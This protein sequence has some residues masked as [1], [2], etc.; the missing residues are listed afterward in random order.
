MVMN[1]ALAVL[2]ALIGLFS[3]KACVDCCCCRCICKSCV[4][5]LWNVLALMMILSFLVGSILALVGRI[6]GDLMSLASFIFSED[7]FNGQ[8]PLFLDKMDS[9]AQGYLRRC[10]IGDGNLAEQLNIGNQIDSLN[11]LTS[12][13]SDISNSLN[14]FNTIRSNC[15]TYNDIKEKLENMRDMSIIF[16]L[17][18]ANDQT[19]NLS[20]DEMIDTLNNKIGLSY[21]DDKDVYKRTGTNENCPSNPGG[22][23]QNLKIST[24]DPYPTYGDTITSNDIG[25][26]SKMVHDTLTLVNV[27]TDPSKANSLAKKV[28]TLYGSYETYLDQYIAIL[29]FLKRE[30]GRITRFINNYITSGDSFSF[31]NGHFIQTNLKILLKYLKHSLGKDFYTVGVCLIVVGCSLILSVSSTILLIVIINI[32]L[33]EDMAAKNMQHTQSPG[34]VIVSEFQTNNNMK[35]MP[36]Y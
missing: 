11:D 6:G 31:L 12:V 7:N 16:Y 23:E 21:P 33:K 20:F 35:N 13:E 29:D 24:C 32:G 1:I 10:I 9:D 2:M 3:M 19:P 18:S 27:A 17:S 15:H 22:S 36:P 30:I 8:N 25:K 34:G 5:I 28:E 14:Q 4:H 26:Y